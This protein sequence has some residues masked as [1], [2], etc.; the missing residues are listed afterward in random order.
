MNLVDTIYI[1][2]PEWKP[3]PHRDAK[4]SHT[5]NKFTKPAVKYGGTGVHVRTHTLD[6]TSIPTWFIGVHP[7]RKNS[8]KM[9][10]VSKGVQFCIESHGSGT[11]RNLKHGLQRTTIS[12]VH[13]ANSNW[14]RCRLGMPIMDAKASKWNPRNECPNVEG[15]L[16]HVRPNKYRPIGSRCSK[17]KD[18]NC[19]KCGRK[20]IRRSCSDLGQLYRKSS[21]LKMGVLG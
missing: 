14:S 11:S 13:D 16:F 1:N 2:L 19:P 15:K 10:K 17:R 9:L 6:K 8:W 18:S 20:K 5:W 4:S 3:G 7:S 12:S 21:K